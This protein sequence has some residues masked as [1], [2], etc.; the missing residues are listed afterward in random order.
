M[1]IPRWTPRNELT[2]RELLLLRRGKL[3]KKLFGFLREQRLLL[4]SNEFQDELATMYR[5]TGEGEVPIAPA[6]MAMAVLLQAYVQSSDAETVELT[7]IDL[8]WQ[9]VLDCLGSEV[10]SVHREMPT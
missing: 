1:T 5:D 2:K 7:I 6:I 3:V 9:M 8:R 4:F 10:V